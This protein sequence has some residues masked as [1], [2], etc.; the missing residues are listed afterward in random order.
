MVKVDV[1]SAY[2]LASVNSQ[3]CPLMAMKWQGKVFVDCMLLF[4]SCSALKSYN[5]IV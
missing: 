1:E 5:A 2:R 4:G 3:D